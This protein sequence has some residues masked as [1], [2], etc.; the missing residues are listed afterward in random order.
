M[1][2]TNGLSRPSTREMYKRDVR[3]IVRAIDNG[4]AAM[5]ITVQQELPD[6]PGI[7]EAMRVMGTNIR[8][9]F[10]ARWPFA[11][12]VVGETKRTS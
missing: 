8:Q 3:R 5:V 10:I 9:D 6:R 4:I 12:D 11:A 2:H 7:V 1:N